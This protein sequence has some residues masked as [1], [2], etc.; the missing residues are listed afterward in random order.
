MT[1]LIQGTSS[2]QNSA[3]FKTIDANLYEMTVV[4]E[5]FLDA[6][7]FELNV[8]MAGTGEIPFQSRRE[9]GP[10]RR[11]QQWFI[12]NHQGAKVTQLSNQECISA[13][14]MS[15]VSGYGGKWLYS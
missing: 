5:R 2:P 9:L 14:G 10:L 1:W 11:K 4:N 12:E 3:V 15:F 6:D 7:L 8:T 13:Y